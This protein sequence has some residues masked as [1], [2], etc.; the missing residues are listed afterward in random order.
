MQVTA[1]AAFDVGG[2]DRFDLSENRALGRAYLSRMYRRY[3]NW[4]DAIAAYNWGPGNLDAWIGGGRAADKLPLEVERYRNRVLREAAL[5]GPGITTAGGWPS[6]AV[7]PSS[8]ASEAPV[9]PSAAAAFIA[10]LMQRGAAA[11]DTAISELAA[12]LRS[13]A[14][15]SKSAY[16]RLAGR[17]VSLAEKR[18]PA[19]AP[20]FE[21]RYA[22]SFEFS[23][24]TEASPL[25]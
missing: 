8:P 11:G 13:R 9:P 23:R 15:D 5:A 22:V 17:I 7:P 14:T 21:A 18:P 4:Q 16:A 6:G 3:G 12:R 10:E 1:A 20:E 2:G 24:L 19:A 25:S